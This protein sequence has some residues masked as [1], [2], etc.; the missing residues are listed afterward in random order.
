M[1]DFQKI[2]SRWRPNLYSRRRK[3][4]YAFQVKPDE[5]FR[6]PSCL[7]DTMLTRNWQFTLLGTYTFTASNVDDTVL[8]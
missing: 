4:E 7:L 2:L 6:F 3:K 1:S 5:T 8:F